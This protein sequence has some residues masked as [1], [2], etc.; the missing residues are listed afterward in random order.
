MGAEEIEMAIATK[1]IDW[2][3]TTTVSR[4]RRWRWTQFA[5]HLGLA[6]WAFHA[7]YPLVWVTITS[8]KFTRELYSDP[9]G[10]PQFWKWSN[11]EEA[12]VYAKMG[13]Y[14]VNSLVVTVG[15]TFL[16]LA[17]ASTS[18][19]ALARFEF[20]F[21]GL[22]WAYILFG[23]LIPHSIL[24]VPLAIFTREIG[25]YN[26]L[27]GLALVY[28]AVGIPWNVFFLR[29]FMETIPRE[30]EEAAVLDGAGMWGV[31]RDVILP[32]STPALATMATFHVLSAWSEYILALVLTGTTD[33]RTLPVGVSL[34]EGHFTSNEPG[35]AAGMVITIVPAVLAFIFLQR[36]VIKGLTAG[37]LKA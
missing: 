2:A 4:R 20:R 3:E 11:Y 10:L 12:W 24:L 13:R 36:Y 22:V 28:A 19:F 29:A 9:F 34:L 6:L 14:F 35:V 25:L 18:A 32:L 17:F 5:L 33:S 8:L 21:K 15:S 16:V 26:S 27:P 30:L 7:V 31:F 1:P 23:F 37:A